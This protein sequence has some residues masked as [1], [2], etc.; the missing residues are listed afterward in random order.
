MSPTVS[1]L[2][3]GPGEAYSAAFGALEPADTAV[4]TALDSGV[5][6]TLGGT[7]GGLKLNVSRDYMK[8]SIDQVVETPGRRLTALE[9][10]LETNLA[11]VT[12]ENWQL[13]LADAASAITASGTGGTLNK[14]MDIAGLE[15]GLEPTYKCIVFR[16]RAPKGKVRQVF[17]RK[18]LSVDGDVEQEYQKDGQTFI[19]VTFASHYVSPSIKA[20]H[21][22]EENTP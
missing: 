3:V 7:D 5:Y 2:L 11:E 17:I 18:A 13:S 9:V 16:G 6:T 14:A 1:N 20:V 4:V 10:T 19:P 15:P 22:Q 12:I 21:V 8:L